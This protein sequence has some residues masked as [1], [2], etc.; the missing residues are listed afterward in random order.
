[1][2]LI[3]AEESYK[4]RGAAKAVYDIL[5]N[6][7]V[8]SIYQEALEIEFMRRNIPYQREVEIEVYYDG[9]LLK[10]KFR[11]DFL[12]Y[13]K[14]IVET[15]AVSDLDEG[16]VLQLSN[17]LKATKLQLGLLVN[18]GHKGGIEIKR[19]VN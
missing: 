15:K 3:Y 14:I 2:A 12:C 11:A 8:E 7:F 4:I 9:I 6:G 18:F 17:Y 16:N 1:M 10:K 19:W 13:D 5:G